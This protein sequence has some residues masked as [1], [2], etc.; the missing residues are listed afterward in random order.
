M[1][2]RIILKLKL[3]PALQHYSVV[4]KISGLSDLHMDDGF[5]LIPL[6]KSQNLFAVRVDDIDRV[7]E[8]K[9]TCPELIEVFGEINVR[10]TDKKSS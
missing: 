1:N 7:E 10:G 5:G 2:K 8:R 6:D 9:K 3:P 4:K